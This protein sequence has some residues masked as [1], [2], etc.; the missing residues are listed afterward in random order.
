[1]QRMPHHHWL[2]GFIGLLT[3]LVCILA[4]HG[5][6]PELSTLHVAMS[7]YVHGHFGWLLSLGLVSLGIGSAGITLAATRRSHD[8]LAKRGAVVGF[9]LWS[10]GVIVAGI[11]PT[12]PRANWDQPPSTAGAIHGIAA[13]VAL[14]AFPAGAI[15]FAY[16]ARYDARWK[17]SIAIV[18]FLTVIVV[19]SYVAF[20]ASL[21]PVFVRPGPPILL[22]LTERVQVASYFVWLA[23]ITIKLYQMETSVGARPQAGMTR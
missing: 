14:T 23:F 3:F 22:G 2:Q 16:S 12:D 1:M 20:A 17:S 10:L 15:A 4:L 9:G 13:I 18:Q 8:G 7:Y 11:F 19:L 5:I 21:T 6:Q